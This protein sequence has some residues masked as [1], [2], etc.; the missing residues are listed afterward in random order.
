MD[1]KEIIVLFS[2]GT[3][4][5]LTAALM[6]ERYEKVRLIT[7]S[8]FG[9][10]SVTN[11][12]INV[13]K[14]KNKYGDAV[15]SHTIINLNKL[16]KYVFYERYLYNLVKHGFLLLTNC[17]LCKL[18]MHVRTVMFCL[19]NNIKNVC[20]GANQGMNIFPAQ[21]KDIIQNLYKMYASFGINYTTPV[22]DFEGPQD[23]EFVDRL[24]LEGYLSGD[25]EKDITDE[26]KKATTGYKLFELGLMPSE[27]VKGTALDRTMQPRCF[28][29]ILFNI[30]VRWY[31]FYNHDYEDYKG[32]ISQFYGEKIDYFT[33]LLHDYV[34]NGNR[35]KLHR[36]KE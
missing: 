6:A 28:Q 20:D 5:T 9:F 34:K 24:H 32:I 33:Q 16:S 19:D 36:L 25:Q 23:I 17:G 26:S 2:G 13:T 3:D 31:Y 30:F 11:P 15:F 27:N 21:M 10:F 7:Y 12:Q 35:S 4:S 18:A 1:N 8:R 29:F 14:L 22:F